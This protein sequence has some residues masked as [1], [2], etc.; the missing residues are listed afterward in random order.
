[1]FAKF[2]RS[3]K[4]KLIPPKKIQKAIPPKAEIIKTPVTYST[5]SAKRKKPFEIKHGRKEAGCR[6]WPEIGKGNVLQIRKTKRKAFKSLVAF[7]F[8]GAH[9]DRKLGKWVNL[10]RGTMWLPESEL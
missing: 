5:P 8:L 2:F 1:M 4:E 7:P 6:W 9:L 3:V 10:N